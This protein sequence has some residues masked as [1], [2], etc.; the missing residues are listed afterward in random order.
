[1]TLLVMFEQPNTTSLQ[2]GLLEIDIDPLAERYAVQ[3]RLDGFLYWMGPKPADNIAKLIVPL[4]FVGSNDL[5]V[6]IYDDSGIYN[7]AIVD[8]VQPDLVNAKTVTLNP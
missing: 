8:K 4:E 7:A 5:Q 6:I 2:R 3:S 1:M